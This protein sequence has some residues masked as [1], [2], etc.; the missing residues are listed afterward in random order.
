MRLKIIMLACILSSAF[1][2]STSAHPL[3]KPV[4][5]R[6]AQP[7]RP[8]STYDSSTLVQQIGRLKIAGV[9][10]GQ[11][12][13]VAL[14]ELEEAGF[15]ITSRDKNDHK[16]FDELVDTYISEGENDPLYMLKTNSYAIHASK[17]NEQITVTMWAVPEGWRVAYVSYEYK[18]GIAPRELERIV[19]EKYEKLGFHIELGSEYEFICIP[20]AKSG[21]EFPSIRI[22]PYFGHLELELAGGTSGEE[23]LTQPFKEAVAKRKGLSPPSF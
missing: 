13:A 18:G 12:E 6:P 16:S 7:D 22:D 5:Q 3:R 10:W 11:R 17:P 1:V 4:A 19:V 8:T 20:S 2:P 21:S 23:T 14:A 15:T 9:S